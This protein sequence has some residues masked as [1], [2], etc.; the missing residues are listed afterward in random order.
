MKRL[1]LWVVLVIALLA[2]VGFTGAAM[3]I[4]IASEQARIE[5][6]APRAASTFKVHETV[7]L[8]RTGFVS[9]P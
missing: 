7:T 8:G 1:G 3:M 6:V 2:M 5:A 4:E 9:A